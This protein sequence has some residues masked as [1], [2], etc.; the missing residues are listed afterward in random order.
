MGLVRKTCCQGVY[1]Q[2]ENY[3]SQDLFSDNARFPIDQE[4]ERHFPH[5]HILHSSL[6]VCVFMS[7]ADETRRGEN[8]R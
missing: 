4:F 8:E 2:I 1:L 3:H 7:H 6:H 5:F